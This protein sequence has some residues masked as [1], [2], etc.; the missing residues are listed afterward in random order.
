MLKLK[1]LLRLFLILTF[2]T[3]AYPSFAQNIE[4]D[5]STQKSSLN[6]PSKRKKNKVVK[7]KRRRRRRR[8]SSYTSFRYKRMKRR[9][10]KIPKIPAPK[11]RAGYRDLTIYSVNLGER[12]RV[13]PFLPNGTL[14]PVAL[15]EISNIMRDKNT[16]TTTPVHPRLVKLL[17]KLVSRVKARQVTLISG[18]RDPGDNPNESHHSN[19]SAIDFMIP[20]VRLPR[21]AKLARRY[22]HVGIGY[23]PSSGFVHMDVRDKVSFFW[24]DRSGPGKG[25]CLR[26][27]MRKAGYKFD[28]KWHP[29]YDEPVVKRN[30]KGKIC[31]ALKEPLPPKSA[32]KLEGSAKNIASSKAS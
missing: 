15:E 24:A 29:K 27:I 18:F 6:A 11:W 4:E 16:H 1:H 28:R 14:D 19:G 30:R 9:W 25:S 23:Y 10:Q 2:F 7:K 26:Q 12:I 21:V 13:F 32:S 3:A 22:G 31:G 20:G 8:C 5:T 17:Y